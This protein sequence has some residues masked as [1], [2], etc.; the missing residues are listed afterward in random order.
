MEIG[1]LEDLNLNING[2]ACLSEM[3]CAHKTRLLHVSLTAES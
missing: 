3:L 2:T 1:Q